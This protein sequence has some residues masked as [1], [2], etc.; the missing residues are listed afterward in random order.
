MK[1]T[2][3]VNGRV[4]EADVAPTDTLLSVLRDALEEHTLVGHV[5]IDNRDPLVVH[6]DDER[7]AE[8][9]ERNHRA[10]VYARSGF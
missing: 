7:V 5:L 8:L 1:I 10:D 9:P 6:R 2:L 3:R 4:R